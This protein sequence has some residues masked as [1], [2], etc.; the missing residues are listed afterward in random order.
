MGC[1]FVHELTHFPNATNDDH[2]D[3]CTQVLV[4][5]LRRLSGIQQYY[6]EEAEKANNR[7]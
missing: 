4:Y 6:K 2:V 5:L 3:A 7:N 1:D